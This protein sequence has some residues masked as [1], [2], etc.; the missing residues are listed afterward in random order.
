[1]L[2]GLGAFLLRPIS[3]LVSDESVISSQKSRWEVAG[4]SCRRRQGHPR[5][6]AQRS[7]GNVAPDLVTAS[8]GKLCIKLRVETLG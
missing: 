6:I 2:S 3:E 5:D 7:A 4:G 1:M 8:G